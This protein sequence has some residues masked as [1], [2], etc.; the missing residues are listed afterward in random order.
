MAK[1]G[2]GTNGFSSGTQ[3]DQ[4]GHRDSHRKQQTSG[5]SIIPSLLHLSRLKLAR[6]QSC[7]SLGHRIEIPVDLCAMLI[8]EPNKIVRRLWSDGRRLRLFRSGLRTHG[9]AK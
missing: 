8:Q 6:V 7:E 4:S 9:V 3:E 5:E 2:R 1:N